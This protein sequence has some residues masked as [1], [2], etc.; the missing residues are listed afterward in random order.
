MNF[1]VI[2]ATQG[3]GL[4]L[5]EQL[6]QAG[7]RVVAGAIVFSPELLSLKDKYPQT[8]LVEKADVTDE[9]QITALA[10]K[11][12]DYLGQIDALCNVAGVLLPGDRVN[13]L[14]KC[15]IAELRRTFDVNTFGPIIVAK[16]FAPA[17]KEGG[18]IF[19]VT[20]E[21][22]AVSACGTWV[23]A[24]A[25]SKMAATKACGIL[26]ASLK[27]VNFIAVHPGRM[28]TEMGRTTAQIE[29]SESAAGFCKLMTGEIPV[30]RTTWYIDYTGEPMPK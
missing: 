11:S 5:T 30:T 8:L 13:K 19:V 18:F 27:T 28:N 10:A 1:V 16:A 4:C 15:D 7:H 14:D 20:S 25:L 23:P 6:L 9:E 17:M 3:L 24:Y 12:K 22:V 2:G 26:N 29:P 21:G